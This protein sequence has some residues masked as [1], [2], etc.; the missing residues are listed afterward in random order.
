MNGDISSALRFIGNC[1]RT[2][3]APKKDLTCTSKK[4]NSIR[5]FYFGAQLKLACHQSFSVYLFT[6]CATKC[7]FFYASIT[8]Q[9]KNGDTL[10]KWWYCVFCVVNVCGSQSS[11]IRRTLQKK[12][13]LLVSLKNKAVLFESAHQTVLS[14]E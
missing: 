3:H 9:V 14:T 4:N 13:P 12:P 2:N 6:R 10:K 7:A 5:I 1:H 11:K 8:V